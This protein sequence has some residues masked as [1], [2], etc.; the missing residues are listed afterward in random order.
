[1][2]LP[3]PVAVPALPRVRPGGRAGWVRH[4]QAHE[5]ICQAHVRSI[6]LRVRPVPAAARHPPPSG[7]GSHSPGQRPVPRPRAPCGHSARLRSDPTRSGAR[8]TTAQRKA[9]PVRSAGSAVAGGRR[10]RAPRLSGVPP[11]P[12][13]AAQPAFRPAGRDERAHHRGRQVFSGPVGRTGG[14]DQARDSDVPFVRP[15]PSAGAGP[16]AGRG[17]PGQRDA[18]DRADGGPGGGAPAPPGRGAARGRPA[19][20][21]RRGA[22]AQ[23]VASP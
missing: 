16:A 5:G 7:E 2:R 4:S 14:A 13:A 21:A 11:G 18:G 12:G 17:R 20:R 1:M 22:P 8:H 3:D 15:A 23:P 10:R 9:G 19:G 6:V